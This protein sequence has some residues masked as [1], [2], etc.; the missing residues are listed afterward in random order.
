MYF[1][2]EHRDEATEPNVSCNYRAL[3]SEGL[4]QG[5]TVIEYIYIIPMSPILISTS[6]K[7][8]F[9][10]LRRICRGSSKHE[11]GRNKGSF[12]S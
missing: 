8:T 9:S 3:K 7:I 11:K 10:K 5:Y 1:V 6:G 2:G 12:H 4:G